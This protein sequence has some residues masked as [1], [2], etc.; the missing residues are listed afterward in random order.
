MR[1]NDAWLA[2]MQLVQ[3]DKRLAELHPE[4]LLRIICGIY[5]CSVASTQS[6]AKATKKADLLAWASNGRGWPQSTTVRERRYI[7]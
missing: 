6:L 3:D 4:S 1:E 7:E 5:R 2:E